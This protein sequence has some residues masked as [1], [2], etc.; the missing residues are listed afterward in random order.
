M[1]DADAA[2]GDVAL[3][4][5]LQLRQVGDAV[6]DEEHLP[7]AAHLEVD[8]VGNDLFVERVHLRLYGI[9]VGRRR[10]YDTEVARP[11]QRELEGAGYGRG[12]QGEGINV[13]LHLPQLLLDADAEL[14][15]LVDDEQAQVLELDVFAQDAVRADEDVDLARGQP[16]DDG[17]CLCRGAGTAE[18]LH[19]A[20]HVLQPLA[21][22]LEVLVG[23]DGGGHQHGHLLVVRHGL[24]RGA[25]G[26]LRLAEAHVA[27]HQAV[28]RAG[29]LHVGLHLGRG[30]A[31]VG[32]VFVEEA[33][34][35]LA[36]QEAVGAELE[37]LLLAALGVQLDEV[38]GNVLNLLLRAVLQ[39]LPSPR[40]QLVQAGRLALLALVFGHFVQGVDGDEHHVVVL[41]DQLHHLLRGVAVGDA[42]QSG[43]APHAVVG[44][45]HVVAGGELVQLLQGKG[46]LAAACLVALEVILMEAVEQLVV[47]EDAEV[48]GVV[49]KAFVQGLVDGGE[50]DA[51]APVVEDG[52]D[53]VGLLAAVAT[54]I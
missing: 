31:L 40:A 11:H 24:E 54:Y 9:A 34:L 20:G 53:A 1:A 36:L 45:H 35:Q 13:D 17:P 42:H 51:V 27:A 23:Q 18:V 6:V 46:H 44:V 50:G 21:E 5:C 28:H 37:A 4:E 30:L 7:V 25:Y 22:G 48:Q 2:V 52:A 49:G 41:I 38:A 29:A 19:A 39:L 3:D 8:G 15:L 43:K 16:L 33:G 10:L 14:L 32:C 47:G 12:S 26:H